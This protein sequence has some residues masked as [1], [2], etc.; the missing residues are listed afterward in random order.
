MSWVTRCA[1]DA[2]RSLDSVTPRI[3]WRRHFQILKARRSF[4]G[5]RA[6]GFQ[7]LKARS[8]TPRAWRSPRLLWGAV[9]ECHVGTAAPQLN[10]DAMF[11]VVVTTRARDLDR[12]SDE[13]M[14]VAWVVRRFER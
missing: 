13:R 6:S 11:E 10:L 12:S 7:N 14:H 8:P 5:E 3:R 1:R 2:T 9:R 4:V